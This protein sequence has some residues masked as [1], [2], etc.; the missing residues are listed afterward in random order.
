MWPCLHQGLGQGNSKFVLMI[1]GKEINGFFF[2]SPPPPTI[3]VFT[4]CD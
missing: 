4:F 1:L 2:L 3:T